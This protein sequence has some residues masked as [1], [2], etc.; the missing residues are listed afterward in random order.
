MPATNTY[1]LYEQLGVK[2]F[3]SPTEL[4]DFIS[5]LTE[6][7]LDE[8]S[9]PVSVLKDTRS[10]FSY[11][12]LLEA[13]NR[14]DRLIP[15]LADPN[16]ADAVRDV[17]SRI[18]LSL[19]EVFPNTFE[20]LTRPEQDSIPEP[21]ES[22]PFELKVGS[23]RLLL[24]ALHV[25]ALVDNWKKAVFLEIDD[26]EFGGVVLIRD[27]SVQNSFNKDRGILFQLAVDGTDQRL[28]AAFFN[29][30]QT[31]C[32]PLANAGRFLFKKTGEEIANRFQIRNSSDRIAD[33]I[34][35]YY[36]DLARCLPEIDARIPGS[37]TL[38]SF[39]RY[40]ER[41]FG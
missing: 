15:R 40:A 21:A 9:V 5:G 18:G 26:E 7:E 24:H 1:N 33:L 14:G 32:T 2:D 4:A 28:N 31:L 30:S 16:D 27:Q 8:L 35:T 41:H 19:K 23:A 13:L 11:D 17:A 10:K 29:A 25:Q 3:A 22:N 34:R 20:V 37:T 6:I 12:L 36:S 39:L 38:K